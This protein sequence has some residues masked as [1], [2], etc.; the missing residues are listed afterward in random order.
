MTQES[1]DEIVGDWSV[2]RTEAVH[3]IVLFI[4]SSYSRCA[5]LVIYNAPEDAGPIHLEDFFCQQ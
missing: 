1:T 4:S 3:V 2:A 5:R